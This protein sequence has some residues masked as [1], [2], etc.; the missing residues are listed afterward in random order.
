MKSYF[1]PKSMY[2]SVIAFAE[3][4]SDMTVRV[5][6]TT[7][8]IVGV[9]QV[10][11]T[12]TPRE[13]IVSILKDSPVNDVDPQVD[14]YLP[15][16][17]INMN[18]M[19]WNSERMR[20]KFEKR[21]LNIEYETIPGGVTRQMQTD[22]Q[23]VPYNLT[24]EVVVWAKYMVDG[25]QIME[26]IL[27]F[28]SPEVHVSTK[29]RNFGI[30]HKS[31]VTLDSIAPNFVYEF[32]EGGEAGRRV[33]QWNLSFTMETVM[34]KPMSLTPEIICSIISI[35]NVPCKRIPFQGNKIVAFDP[36]SNIPESLFDKP[37]SVALFDLDQGESYDLMANFWKQSN[38]KMGMEYQTCIDDNCDTN[39]GPRPTWDPTLDATPCNPP[40]K[41]PLLFV[42]PNTFQITTYW[43]DQVVINS[44]IELNSYVQ[45][46][47]ARGNTL[48]GPT[49]IPLSAYPEQDAI[50]SAT[51]EVS[52][53]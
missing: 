40:N 19:A 9:K 1:Y 12:L 25:M 28:F 24:F 27:P 8:Y 48:S 45:V 3:L 52:G 46:Y 36:V 7:G 2:T 42:D 13:K 6:D 39:P 17:S 11:A 20:G 15:R 53:S 23:S 50:L 14:N 47:D 4:F 34:W 10:P 29:E 44:V 51:R 21:L 35:A 41:N 37:T 22:F 16:I 49:S 5:Y 38:R 33:L 32:G 18:G 31:K 30:E 26:N 43:Q